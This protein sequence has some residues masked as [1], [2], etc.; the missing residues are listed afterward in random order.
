[1]GALKTAFFLCV[2]A[3]S[4]VAHAQG[5]ATSFNEL[6]LLVKPGDTIRVTSTGGAEVTGRL[7]D[8]S[9]ASLVLATGNNSREWQESDVARIRQRRGDSLAN[10]ALWGLAAGAAYAGV[11]VLSAP[12]EFETA[13]IAAAVIGFFAAAGTG[14]GVGIDAL[15]RKDKVIYEP[16]SR[17]TGLEVV[18]LVGTGRKGAL[19]SIRF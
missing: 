14:I 4:S 16:R 18:P 1:M 6:R 15:I 7:V 9:S 2:M 12:E 17:A 13:G 8:L 10:G 5:I 11:G 19:L 3:A